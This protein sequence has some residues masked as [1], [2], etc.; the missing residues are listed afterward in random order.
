VKPERRSATSHLARQRSKFI[1]NDTC[2]IIYYSQKRRGGIPIHYIFDI[3]VINWKRLAKS[4]IHTVS[5]CIHRILAGS[6]ASLIAPS[7]GFASSALSHALFLFKLEIL[8][9]TRLVRC[10]PNFTF[11]AAVAFAGRPN[12]LLRESSSAFNQCFANRGGLSL[13]ILVRILFLVRCVP[14][15]ALSAAVTGLARPMCSETS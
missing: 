1:G 13:G 8:P 5:A 2:K 3:V 10:V 11:R 4:Y 6:V 14:N 9:T 15:L 12:Q 7:L